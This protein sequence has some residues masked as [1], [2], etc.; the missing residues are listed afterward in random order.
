MAGYSADAAAERERPV[1]HFGQREL[2]AAFLDG[3][4]RT[5]SRLADS[6]AGSNADT[7]TLSVSDGT[8]ALDSTSGLTFTAGS[9]G[10]SSMTVSGTLANLNAALNGLLYTPNSGY[11]GSDPLHLSLTD[12]GDSL[13]GSSDRRGYGQCAQPADRHRTDH[14][15]R[16]R[17]LDT[18]L[19]DEPGGRDQP[20]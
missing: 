1:G 8:L 11:S 5:R 18:A 4:R 9:N 19:F 20:G 10:S 3:P 12:P 13:T 2:D 6:Q 17:E 14:H 16:Q 15:F 7:L